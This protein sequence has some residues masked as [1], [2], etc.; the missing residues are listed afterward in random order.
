MILIGF[1]NLISSVKAQNSLTEKALNSEWNLFNATTDSVRAQLLIDKS[2]YQRNE[3]PEK[4]LS[5]LYRI[6]DLTLNRD[7]H[8][9]TTTSKVILHD[10]LSQYELGLYEIEKS[11]VLD[12]GNSALIFLKIWLL[13][14]SHDFEEAEKQLCLF[15]EAKGIDSIRTGYLFAKNLKW[16]KAK[17]ARHLSA[18]APGLGQ[19]YVGKIGHSLSSTLLF[20][21]FT[22]YTIF[23]FITGYPISATLTGLTGV[24]RFYIGGQR[25]ASSLAQTKNKKKAEKLKESAQVKLLNLLPIFQ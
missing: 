15:T 14:N 7:Q 9:E 17:R 5:T 21:A 24:F 16:K 12:S 6:D 4:A 25:N 2:N 23:S 18:L 8:L 10:K 13:T 20:G 1:G 19:L 11:Q 3:N 22:G